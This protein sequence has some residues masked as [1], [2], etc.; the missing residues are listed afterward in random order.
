VLS[1]LQ[2][3]RRQVEHL[4]GLHARHRRT[5][6]VGTAPTAPVGSVQGHLVGLLHLR[7]VGAR[8]AGLLAGP[9]TFGPPIGAARS[10]R[11]LAQPIRGR[12]PRGVGGVLAD[13]TLQLGHPR[14]QHGD[15]A[16]LLGV[17]RTQLD[18]DRSLDHDGR[19]QIRTGGRDRGL[20]NTTTSGHA[21]L[22]MGRTAQLHPSRPTVNPVAARNRVLNSYHPCS[23]RDELLLGVRSAEVRIGLCKGDYD[24]SERLTQAIN[25]R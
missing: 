21:R 2:A 6:Q 10:P 18:D 25:R 16:G 4:P 11:G 14:L 22:P 17:G 23:Q 5:R 24:E 19:F 20:Q 12:R 7:Q 3:K 8:G 1:D 13:P 9:A 15:Q